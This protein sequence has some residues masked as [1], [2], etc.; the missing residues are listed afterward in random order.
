MPEAVLK[1]LHL[2]EPF[3]IAH[4]VSSTRQVVRITGGQA[5]GEAPFVPYYGESPE[6]TLA[7]L[8]GPQVGDG[9]RAGRL[10]LDLFQ[11]DQKPEPLWHRAERIL[12]PGRPWLD[13]HACRSLGIPT[14]L[15]AFAEKVCQT[16][17]QFRVLKLKLGSGD[18]VH[19]EAIVATA[20]A[21]APQA[22]MFADVNGGW[23]VDETVQMLPRL[24]RYDLAL[25]E[26][27][28]HHHGGVETWS[29]L[30]SKLPSESLPLYADESA[31]NA[32][33]VHH[34]APLVQGV[35]VKLLK[36]GSFAGGIE[37]IASARQH[38]LGIILGC[39]IE[40]SL[41]TTAAAHLAPW[42]DYVDLDGHLYLADDDYLGITFDAEGRLLMP[43]ENG[44][45]ARP[46]T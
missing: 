42:A 43:Q 20:R 17:R 12:G 31:Q 11:A 32:D 34:L 38:G 15:S 13:I 33:D 41:G 24:A 7:W 44:I 8:Q 9:T 10:A 21:A 2:T 1:T 28:I 5:T 40:S 45:G 26:Q 14:D 3:R 16:A 25:V 29:E 4:G 37:M 6:D 35:N 18:L 36:C 39:M 22:T 23:S 30:R 46:R 27:P 19:D